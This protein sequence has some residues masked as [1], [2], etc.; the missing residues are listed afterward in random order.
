MEL[1][2]R[3]VKESATRPEIFALLEVDPP[4]NRKAALIGTPDWESKLGIGMIRGLPW[5]TISGRLGLIYSAENG[6][7]DSGEYAIE[8]LKRLSPRWGVY[9]GIEGEQDEVEL[10]GEA[11]WHF[12]PRAYLR[13]NLA[14]GLSN[15]AVD[16]GP[17]VGVVFAFPRR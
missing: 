5:G 15:K 2:W 4:S 13:L 16:W 12:S 8:Y 14:R 11:Q 7:A 6:T 9:G 1:D 17:D 10:I 3:V